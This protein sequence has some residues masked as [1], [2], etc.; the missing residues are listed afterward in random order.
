MN[1]TQESTGEL[2]A[3]VK[4]SIAEDDYKEKVSK[5]IKEHQKKASLKGFRPGKVPAS[6]IQKMYGKSILAEEVDKMLSESLTGYLIDNKINILG[7]PLPSKE[8][9]VPIDFDNQTEF[10]FYFDIGLAPEFEINIPESTELTSYEI[11]VDN[12]MLEKEISYMK[13]RFGKYIKADV[14]EEKDMLHGVFEELDA[15]AKV[16]EGGIQNHTNVAL[17]FLKNESI[18]KKLTGCKSN[19]K[20]IFT[21]AEMFENEDEAIYHLHLKKEE[22]GNITSDFQ[23]TVEEISRVELA[24]INEE[25]FKKVFPKDNIT[26]EQEFND[27]VKLNLEESLK[28]ESEKKLDEDIIDY[29]LDTN[30]FNLPEDFLKRWL[31]ETNEKLTEEQIEHDFEHYSEHIKWEIVEGKLIK[32]NKFEVTHDEV[33]EFAKGHAKEQLLSYGLTAEMITDEYLETFSADM[34]KKEETVRGIYDKV[35]KQKVMDFVKTKI[36][37]KTQKISVDDFVKLHSKHNH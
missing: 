32:D 15:E 34:L 8:K 2:T 4:V 17:E 26:N 12:D 18:K 30:K 19:D 33:K 23:F 31:K 21:P 24:E 27:K 25:F 29:I 6:L 10:D 14:A 7:Q 22:I 36:K 11:E 9:N 28:K 5:A 13:K 20:I 37:N 16:K 1:I 3:I 35:Y